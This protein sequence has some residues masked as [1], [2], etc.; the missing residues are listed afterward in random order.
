[1]C[2]KQ[3]YSLINYYDNKEEEDVLYDN[4]ICKI[5]HIYL[6]LDKKKLI[7]HPLPR[8]NNMF[9]NPLIESIVYHSF[10]YFKLFI[11][12]FNDINIMIQNK[13]K[14]PYR[15]EKCIYEL[16]ATE[17]TII[18]MTE[19]DSKEDS[20][21][22]IKEVIKDHHM[23]N[24]LTKN[25]Y[26]DI[27]SINNNTNKLR[28]F[29]TEISYYFL[30]KIRLFDTHRENKYIRKLLKDF[31]IYYNNRSQIKLRELL[32]NELNELNK[33]NVKVSYNTMNE[34]TDKFIKSIIIPD[35]TIK[36]VNEDI[37]F[38]DS[39]ILK[40]TKLPYIQVSN[41]G[42]VF[43]NNDNDIENTIKCKVK[44]YTFKMSSANDRTKHSFYYRLKEIEPVEPVEPIEPVEQ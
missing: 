38:S 26:D 25:E 33:T 3:I 24:F 10:N 17:D 9:H 19:E 30:P 13:G 41:L 32:D 15:L 2:N 36:Y 8:K 14:F 35:P 6:N 5:K 20:K 1:M 39:E 7:N 44:Q 21:E 37:T 23:V 28:L 43:Y 11:C 34:E 40:Q 22:V 12:Q 16:N 31:E 29:D 27:V 18:D 42:N 4:I